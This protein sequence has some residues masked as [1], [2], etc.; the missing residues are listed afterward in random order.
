MKR[1]PLAFAERDAMVVAPALLN[2]V[3]L[4]NGCSARI[5][6]V[7]AYTAD[8]PASHSFKGRTARNSSMFGPAGHWYVYFIYGMH[9]CLNLVTG[10]EGDGQAV[11]VRAV[12]LD[13]IDARLTTGPGRLTRRMGVDLSL[14]GH[15]AELFDDGTAPPLAP[16]ISAR[17]GISSAVDW[18]RRWRVSA[19]GSSPRR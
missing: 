7:E 12:V 14:N 3:A 18:P 1:L 6:E 15:L 5:T 16:Q 4:V 2:K 10:A 19:E 8:D 9:H 11:L 17:V 13:G